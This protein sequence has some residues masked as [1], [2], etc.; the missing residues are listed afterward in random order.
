MSVQSTARAAARPQKRR[1]PSPRALWQRL[2]ADPFHMT[3]VDP[4]SDCDLKPENCT[5]CIT[6]HQARPKKRLLDLFA[7]EFR[8]NQ[9]VEGLIRFRDRIP[10]P[11]RPCQFCS[12]KCSMFGKWAAVRSSFDDYHAGRRVTHFICASCMED[13]E[14]MMADRDVPE[15]YDFED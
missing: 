8:R 11:L 3:C 4:F 5:L 7:S 15:Y 10:N 14:A 2:H 1:W 12:R 13:W 9:I 6:H